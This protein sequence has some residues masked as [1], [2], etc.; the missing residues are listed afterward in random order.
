MII[1]D[2]K[3]NTVCLID[4]NT[5][6]VSTKYKGFNSQFVLPIGSTYIITRNRIRTIIKR[7]AEYQYNTV[8]FE[9]ENL[10]N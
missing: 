4:S 5:G 7:E 9:L 1:K 8:S 3:N 6:E 2:V 10:I